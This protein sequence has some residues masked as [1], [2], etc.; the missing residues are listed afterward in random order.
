[1][2][3]GQ[4]MVA[5][6]IPAFMTEFGVSAGVAAQVISALSVG[7]VLSL[8][9][10]GMAVD[11]FGSR[12]TM[13]VGAAIVVLGTV[14]AVLA[15]NFVLLLL[16][17]ACVGAGY[18]TWMLG[19]EIAAIDLVSAAQ[20]G[21]M[22]SSLF[23]VSVGG[24]ALGPILGGLLTEQVNFRAALA[25][26]CALASAVLLAGLVRR[27]ALVDQPVRRSPVETRPT[28]RF[29]KLIPAGF[30]MTFLV[31]LAATCSAQLRQT[32]LNTLLPIYG[33]VERNLST[34]QVGTLFG[35][36]GVANLAMIGPVGYLSDRYGRKAAIVP[37][38][39]LTAAALIL[40]PI[41][42]SYLQLALVTVIVG[43][44]GGLALA[45]MTIS[46]YDIAPPDVRGIMQSIRR[47]V[48]ELGSLAGPVLAGAIVDRSS[49]AVAFHVFAPV[50]V[51]VAYLAIVVARETHPLKQPA[52]PQATRS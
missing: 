49:S 10:S 11:R 35:I 32:L 14:M 48:G 25:L 23:G 29:L 4:G 34:T 27:S 43:V 2:S 26:F 36:I 33:T 1:M 5:P 41:A 3:T 24:M 42:Q 47:G 45:S 38:L 8:A 28:L 39:V 30:R 44:G 31:L 46:T 50:F 51:L 40:Y 21:R 7:R 37:S 17:Q 12:W 9:P 15:P 16:A 52:A 6:M 20:R 13:L 19:R 18:S 22:L